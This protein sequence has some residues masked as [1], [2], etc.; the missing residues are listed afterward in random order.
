[1]G[2]E[3]IKGERVKPIL[4]VDDDPHMRVALTEVLTREGYWVT[5]VPNGL[6]AVDKFQT[7]QFDLVFTDLKMPGID[8]MGVLKESKKIAPQTPV[9]IMTAYGTI[10]NAVEA[11]RIGASDYL[12]KPF[13]SSAVEDILNRIQVSNS[14]KQKKIPNKNI[15]T[16]DTGMKNL[17][18]ILRDVSATEATVLVQGESGTGKELI[19]NFIHHHSTRVRE[20]FVAI[21]C[22]ALPEGLLESELFGYEKGAFTNALGRKIGKFEQADGGTLFLDEITELSLSLQPKLLRVLQEREVDRVGGRGPV[23]VNVRLIASTN[24]SLKKEVEAGRFREDLYYRINV[25]PVTLPLLRERGK[26]IQLLAE[27]FLERHRKRMGRN[28]QKLSDTAREFLMKCE[29]KGNVRELENAMERAILL[30]GGETLLP[31]HFP[32][33][34]APVTPRTVPPETEGKTVWKMERD[35]ILA[36]LSQVQGNRTHA[37]KILGI[38]LR[39]LRN[40]IRE[41][42]SMQ[43]EKTGQNIP[44]KD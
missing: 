30:A 38:S 40:K 11:M 37:A 6:D 23:P 21:N 27:Y 12:L 22:A 8:G 31:E 29:W 42:Q 20:N 41:Y 44:I 43:Q 32:F 13:S 3:K 10:D 26:D 18:R 2:V 7:N 39:T 33:E 14:P 9:V 34:D 19:A 4:V 24:K 1:M 28:P 36:T 25:F 15:I 5:A 17:L 16:Q 35:L